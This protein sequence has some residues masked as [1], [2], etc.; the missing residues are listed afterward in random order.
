MAEDLKALVKRIARKGGSCS[1]A[2]LQADIRQFLLTAPLDLEPADLQD[3]HLESPVGDRRRIDIEAG[4][5]VIEVKRELRKGSVLDDA[6]EQLGGYVSARESQT[7]NRYVGVLTDGAEW[8]CYHS[9]AD[10]LAEVSSHRVSAASP[11]LDQL[12]IWLDGVMATVR[13]LAPTLETIRTRMGAGMSWH[14]LDQATLE[15]LFEK[16]KKSQSLQVKREL[17]ARL[18]TSALGSQFEDTDELFVEHTLLVN[19]AEIIAHAVLGLQVELLPPA[20]LLSGSKL[21]EH[22]IVGVVDSD[23]FDWVVEIPEG[24]TFIRTLA[25]RLARFDWSAVEHD[26]LKILY[27]SVISQD[28]RK[29]LGEYYTPDWLA[30]HVVETA[31]QDPLRERVLDAACGSGT[32]L[33]HAVRRYIAAAEA[34]RQSLPELLRGVTEHV[35]GVD[36]HPVAVTL[37][38]VTYLLAI[39]RKRLSDPNRSHVHVPVYLGDAMQWRQRRKDLLTGDQLVIETDDG[40]ELFASELRL[41]A[42]LLGDAARFDQLVGELAKKATQSGGSTS[43]TAIFQRFAVN[44]EDQAVI[45]VTFQ[46]MCALHQD[47]RNH[48][49]GYFVRNLARP[50]WLARSENRV[51]VL[52]GNP[53]W[54]AYRHMTP[55]MQASFQKMSIARGLWQGAAVATHQDLSGLFVARIAQLYLKQGGRLALVMPNAVVDR[56]QFAGFRSGLFPDSTD[57]TQIEFSQP[58]DLRRLRPHFFPRAAAV[59]F[60]TKANTAS[61]MPTL[62]QA[63]SGR[64][65]EDNPDWA[66]VAKAVER[67]DGFAKPFSPDIESPYRTRFAQGAIFAPR[68]LFV[69]KRQAPG[70]LGVPTGQ[71]R[72][73]SHRSANEKKPWKGIADFEGIVES[74]FVRPLLSG[75]TTLP[76]RTLDA[77]EVILPW[78]SG[79]LLE[80][81]DERLDLYP[82]L[83]D[84]WRTAEDCWIGHRSSARLTLREQLDY[85]SKL[86]RQFPIQQRRVVYP[87]SGMHLVAARVNLPRAV[88]NNSLYWATVATDDEAHY[89][90][91]ILNSPITTALVRP[92]MSYG[93]DERDFHKHIWQVPV[94]EFDSSNDLHVALSRLGL[95]A[96][97]LAAEVDLDLGKHFSALR[98][99][100][101]QHLQET[102]TGREID[103]LVKDLLA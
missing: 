32:F 16:H 86:S 84:W 31:V 100:V 56:A 42:S 7:G 49:W 81:S 37:A 8:R 71:V 34:A 87:K 3:I 55:D 85:R 13:G 6:V 33:F 15:A 22:G 95:A 54:L 47:G 39:G 48:I 2:T 92:L 52:V 41:P 4:S 80:S 64:V 76:F 12:L 62:V 27:E 72:V 51:D 17:W 20:T 5:T 14:D 63:W 69:V 70:P 57:P 25:R 98:R 89:L 78:D 103:E 26:V 59:V 73:C 45:T 29:R 46:T 61:V 35:V 18:L 28:T 101:R 24:V 1:E 93:K 97:K 67:S 43:L 90:C 58:W 68:L 40:R 11:D 60:G 66:S 23:F 53:P 75:E 82:G 50:V 9:S 79:R 102:D 94:P 74:E 36:L 96:E 99:Q 44:S 10:R 77:L 65:P 91:A 83:A 21:T 88:I 38:R 30:E 19:T